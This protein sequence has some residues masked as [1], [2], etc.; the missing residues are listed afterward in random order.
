MNRT[1]WLY[2]P[3]T[4]PKLWRA[5]AAVLALTVLAELFVGLHAEFRFADWFS[6]NAL[7]G[8]F[9]CT[10]MVLFAKWLGALIKKPDDY[11]APAATHPES[12]EDA[13]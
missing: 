1:H 11:Y 6:F 7:Y 2:R 8:F 12:E 4:V 13:P 10:I 5:G 9:S 3:E